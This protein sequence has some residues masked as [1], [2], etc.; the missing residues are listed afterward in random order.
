MRDDANLPQNAEIIANLWY[1]LD[2]QGFIYSLRVAL[3][4]VGGSEADKL[5]FLAS[6][7]YL[8]YLVARPFPIPD[9]FAMT[10][11]DPDGTET[12]YPVVHHDSMGALGGIEQLFFDALDQLESDLPAQTLLKVPESPLTKVTAL[13]GT[14][15][16]QVLPVDAM[17]G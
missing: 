12:T 2:D 17:R 15:D 9:R 6:R 3:Y 10:M 11:V 5:A 7:A 13:V 1:V 8:D 16:G 4:V 14:E